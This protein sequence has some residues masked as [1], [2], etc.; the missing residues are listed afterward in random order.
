MV[1]AT[2]SLGLWV[3]A[4][5]A[6]VGVFVTFLVKGDVPAF[7]QSLAYVLIGGVV[8]VAIPT[9]TPPVVT[10]AAAPVHVAIVPAPVPPVIVPGA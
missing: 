9:P 6:L 8:G 1:K 3:L 10:T 4:I 2:S 5:L 7:E